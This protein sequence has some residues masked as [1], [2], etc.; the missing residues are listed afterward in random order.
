[1]SRSIYF[2]LL[3]TSWKTN[4]LKILIHNFDHLDLK[5]RVCDV[6]GIA[7]IGSCY[8]TFPRPLRPRPHSKPISIISHPLLPCLCVIRRRFYIISWKL[9]YTMSTQKQCVLNEGQF[10]NV[11]MDG[12][13]AL[14]NRNPFA[15]TRVAFFLSSWPLDR[16][17]EWG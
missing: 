17:Q 10:E 4:G 12:N 13:Q 8:G 6:F 5:N 9:L 2:L 14:K 15:E 7:S 16:F 1:M 3:K 11:I